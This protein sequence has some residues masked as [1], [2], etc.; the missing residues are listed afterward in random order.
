MYESK[1]YEFKIKNKKLKVM[2]KF[3]NRVISIISLL[4]LLIIYFYYKYVFKNEINIYVE[5]FFILIFLYLFYM[6]FL[7]DENIFDNIEKKLIIKR[8]LLFIKIIKEIPYREIET[9]DIIEH[10]IGYKKK[11][12]YEFIMYYKNGEKLKIGIFNDQKIIKR[13]KENIDL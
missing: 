6:T 5:I 2:Y 13:F 8:G 11:K 7:I 10:E 1:W 4:F 12:M 3:K 9:I